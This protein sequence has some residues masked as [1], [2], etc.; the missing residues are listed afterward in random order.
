MTDEAET[1]SVTLS[2]K[3]LLRLRVLALAL[4][5]LLLAFAVRI[6]LLGSQ[7]LWNDEGNSY[8]QATRTLAA[9]A[10]NAARDI[11]PPGYYWLLHGWLIASGD[12]EFSLRALSAFASVLTVAF[13]FAL[14]RWLYG[15]VAGLAAAL[16]LALNTFSI[17]YAQEARMYALL[18]LWGVMGFWAL[19][20]F[21]T[22]ESHVGA[23]RHTILQ[24]PLLLAIINAAGLWTQYAYP[25][26]MLAQG[27]VFVV[28]WV[29]HIRARG[30]K[31]ASPLQ[32][33][34]LYV[35]ANGLTLLL[36]LPWLPAAWSQI[37]T[38]PS[39]GEAIPLRQAV[40]TI[41]GWFTLG[42]TYTVVDPSWIAVGLFLLL[43]GLFVQR[44]VRDL[45]RVLLPVA[46]VVL[47][48]GL[49]L[50]LGLF[51]PSNLKF[52][53]P[54][55]VGFALWLGRGVWVLWHLRS[56]R[57]G[58]VTDSPL[59]Y[60]PLA[61]ALVVILAL[62]A[63]LWRGLD[64]LYHHPDFHRADYR[65][66]AADISANLRAGDAVILDAPNQE[67]VFRYYYAAAAPVYPLPPGLGRR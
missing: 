19:V 56:S 9:I 29:G 36:Y 32:R 20:G 38:W 55:G 61:A 63:N 49:F 67:E 17:F 62:G 47:P 14:G 54:A 40:S 65:G 13:T 26:M 66:I 5:I 34:G 1:A 42:V 53:L 35:V 7:S 25:F 50:G 10:D 30:A 21:V 27:V 41:L 45:W 23:H 59:R 64:P 51:R 57:G 58:R 52:L 39:T 12:S 24:W 31:Q 15:P 33:I 22:D 48:V 6:H 18:A 44:P 4:F 28:W 2:Q 8:V 16:F 46:W 11:H 43:F 37:T 3:P 60:L